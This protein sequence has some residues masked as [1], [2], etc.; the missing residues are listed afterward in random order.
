[1]NNSQEKTTQSP[2]SESVSHEA[3]ERLGHERSEQLQ[4]K[5]ERS[6]KESSHEDVND[7]HKEALE[8]A[9][10]ASAEQEKREISPAERRVRGPISKD[11]RDASFTATMQEIRTH[12]STPSRTFSKAI[13]NKTVERVSEATGSTIARP[14]AILSGAVAAFVVTL[15]IYVVAKNYGYP[16]SG[17]ESIAAFIAGWIIGLVYDFLK[18]MITGRK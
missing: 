5:L 4:E 9:A 6:S 2:E 14:N 18:V 8:H 10:S 16:L 15:V 12:M 11:E 3:L 1:M 7:L 17:F 13:H